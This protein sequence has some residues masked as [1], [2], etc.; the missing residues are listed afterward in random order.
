[1]AKSGQVTV[2]TAGTAV[3]GPD[4]LGGEFFLK[5]HPDNTDTVWVGN[6]AGDVANSNGFPLNPGETVLVRLANLMDL[7]FDS[8]V[9]GEKVCWLKVW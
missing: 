4:E 7:C 6:V 9:N 8:D 5:A 1:M 2:T 3:T